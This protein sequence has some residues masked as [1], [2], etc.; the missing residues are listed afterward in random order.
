MVQ[1]GRPEI[2]IPLTSVWGVMFTQHWLL[3]PVRGGCVYTVPQ[4]RAGP[5]RASRG[6]AVRLGGRE[7]THVE[8]GSCVSYCVPALCPEPCANVSSTSPWPLPSVVAGV[9]FIPQRGN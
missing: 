7:G 8:E 1:P 9:I 2:V 5:G 4:S 6:T 3:L